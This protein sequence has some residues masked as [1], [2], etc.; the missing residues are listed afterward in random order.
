MHAVVEVHIV[1]NEHEES[2]IEVHSVV[3]GGDPWETVFN[4]VPC[5]IG[6]EGSTSVEPEVDIVVTGVVVVIGV[7]SG[8]IA[9]IVPSTVRDGERQIISSG[10]TQGGELLGAV[11][12]WKERNQRD[13]VI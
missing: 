2:V 7:Q 10:G 12:I 6:E 11:S 13:T 9:E 1:S 4:M 5:E 3:V 8:V